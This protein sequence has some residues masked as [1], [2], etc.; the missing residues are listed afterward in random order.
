M[1]HSRPILTPQTVLSLR[2]VNAD[3]CHFDTAVLCF[4]GPEASD[5]LL[6]AF[7]VQKQ[8]GLYLYGTQP[9]GGE[10]GEKHLLILPTLIWGGPMMGILL[11]EL[12]VLGIKTAIGFGAAGSLVSPDHMGGLL[13]TKAALCLD[14]ASREY[15]DAELAYPDPDLLRLAVKL[16]EA[17]AVSPILSTINTTD[18]LYR[19]TPGKI[20]QWRNL[21]A[22]FV[23]LETGPFYAVAS[24]LEMRAVY[25]GLVTDYVAEDREWQHGYW[26]RENR[27]DPVIVRVIR[28]LVEHRGKSP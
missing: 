21:G 1:N 8:E 12:A 9:H 11:E 3:E 7:Q 19:E 22:E 27:T 28:G 24:F 25:L 23:N 6:D 2:G 15:A 14:G 17:Q 26:N 5:L 4:R 18:A 16:S 13:I 10:V 20:A